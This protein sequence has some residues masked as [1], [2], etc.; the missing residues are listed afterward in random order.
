MQDETTLMPDAGSDEA[1][2]PAAPMA[3]QDG[4]EGSEDSDLEAEAGGGSEEA[5]DSE[6]SEAAM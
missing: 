1:Q 3:P 4:D 6:G 5:G 2:V